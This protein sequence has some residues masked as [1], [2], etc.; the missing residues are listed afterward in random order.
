VLAWGIA[1]GSTTEDSRNSHSYNLIQ[2]IAG[3]DDGTGKADRPHVLP[4][5][6]GAMVVNEAIG[7]SGCSR[8]SEVACNRPNVSAFAIWESAKLARLVIINSTPFLKGTVDQKPVEKVQL[9]GLP[10]GRVKVKRLTMPY[11]DVGEGMLVPLA[12][13]SEL[14]E[15][16][17]TFILIASGLK[18]ITMQHLGL[19]QVRRDSNRY[20]TPVGWICQHPK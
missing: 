4:S 3:V 17:S 12:E 11:T 6:Y 10:Q 8:V 15:L 9:D 19:S 16:T 13:L 18:S 2:P 5:Y 20:Q 7:S 14:L 1:L